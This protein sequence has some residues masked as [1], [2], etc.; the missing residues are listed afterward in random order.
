MSIKTTEY[1]YEDLH[2]GKCK[3]CNKRTLV[4]EDEICPECIE[5]EK[6]FEQSMK[7]LI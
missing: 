4:T 5:D 3:S 7:G 1:E 6:F 2:K